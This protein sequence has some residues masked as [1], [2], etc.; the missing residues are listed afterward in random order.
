MSSSHAP[1][2][3]DRRGRTNQFTDIGVKGRKTG[4]VV[5]DTGR[6]D[7]AGMEDMNGFFSPDRPATPQAPNSSFTKRLQDAANLTNNNT[8][9]MSLAQSSMREPA[10]IVRDD[11]RVSA[12]AALRRTPARTSLNSPALRVRSAAKGQSSPKKDVSASPSRSSS[13]H[14][15]SNVNVARKID[16]NEVKTPARKERTFEPEPVEEDYPE[17]QMGDEVYEDNEPVREPEVEAEASPEPARAPSATKPKPRKQTGLLSQGG[18]KRKLFAMTNGGDVSG[19][20]EAH[21]G[22]AVNGAEEAMSEDER[23]P[24][25]EVEP[26]M[27]MEPEPVQ[28]A[29]DE[30]VEEAEPE[31]AQKKRGRPP[32]A[33]A[34]KA[35]E[36]DAPKKK[37]KEVQQVEESENEEEE[38]PA[39][40]KKRGRP[41]KNTTK[42]KE[43]IRP[44]KKTK[45]SEPA[46]AKSKK[47]SKGDV[48]LTQAKQVIIHEKPPDPSE[49]FSELGSDVRRSRR[50]R[51]APLAFWKNEKIV[52]GASDRRKSSGLVL[53]EM[54][55][56][57]RVE[58]TAPAKTKKRAANG[59]ARGRKRS[60]KS[61]DS[62]DEESDED[63]EEEDGLMEA[64]VLGWQADGED[65]TVVK[66]I[67]CPSTQIK[68]KAVANTSM[69]YQKI[70][71]VN[72]F[73]ATGVVD[74]P[75]GAEKLPRS[76]KQNVMIFAVFEGVLEVRVHDTTFKVKKGGQFIVPRGNNYSFKNISAAK[77][78][79]LFFTH[80]TD[81]L[82]NAEAEV[83]AEAAA[84]GAASDDE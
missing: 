61:G 83:E 44:A 28:E 21:V 84:R 1:S 26:E 23:M 39:P 69:R 5:K 14:S 27:D 56:I 47:L 20:L 50:A 65:E 76:S 19:D 22:D 71:T 59:T 60:L 52:Y 10:T 81:T 25:P 62:S 67:A 53:P 40:V 11:R 4:L 46:Q 6:R 54:K 29:F 79:R 73:V 33:V 82:A 48:S 63:I 68:P 66:V 17:P 36:Q 16:F 18:K 49:D 2:E 42:E 9:D 12:F 57:I 24:E 70:F 75:P 51:V 35:K 31:P 30:D 77:T 45:T 58:E 78:A 41:P 43:N 80:A 37:A 72:D 32:K 15:G 74:L 38:A 34:T 55:E 13:A 8:S 7:S 3:A 64:Q